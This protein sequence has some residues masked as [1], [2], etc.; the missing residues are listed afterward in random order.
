M[1]YLC[2]QAY[3]YAYKHML[4]Y[5]FHM[6]TFEFIHVF[7]CSLSLWCMLKPHTSRVGGKILYTINKTLR[8]GCA[9]IFAPTN[10]NMFGHNLV[11]SWATELFKASNDVESLVVSLFKK[12]Q[13]MDLNFFV[14]DVTSQLGQVWGF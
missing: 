5:Y 1:Y 3:A 7:V 4:F 8:S 6:Y 14:R 2:L 12:W 11:A 13:A 9:T 10:A